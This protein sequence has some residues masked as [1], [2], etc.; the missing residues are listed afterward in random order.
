MQD[1]SECKR[2]FIQLSRAWYAEANLRDVDYSD[3]ITIGF[4]HPEGGTTGEFEISFSELGGRT[5][6]KLI[7]F[8]DSWSALFNF[9]DLIEK[10]ADIDDRCISPEKFCE[11]LKSLGIEDNTPEECRQ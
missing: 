1:H 10:M 2:Q 5:V 7:A 4:Y 11:L 3:K 8:D 9:G 6:P